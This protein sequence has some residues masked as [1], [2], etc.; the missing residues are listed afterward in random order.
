MDTQETRHHLQRL[1]RASESLH[2]ASG[3]PS[4]AMA[5]GDGLG[6]VLAYPDGDHVAIE[7]FYRDDWTVQARSQ[8]ETEWDT[9]YR[10]NNNDRMVQWWAMHMI[11]FIG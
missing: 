1:T 10:S 6:M 11:H 5:Y 3:V 7:C 9:L 4:T 8:G 2:N